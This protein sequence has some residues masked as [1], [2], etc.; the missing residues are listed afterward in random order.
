M[1]RERNYRVHSPGELPTPAFALWV[2]L[3][4]EQVA[5]VERAGGSGVSVRDFLRR[6]A[7]KAIKA[8]VPDIGTIY[9]ESAPEEDE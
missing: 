7:V 2:D 4:R 6:V 1:P 5:A 3:T 8:K 9:R